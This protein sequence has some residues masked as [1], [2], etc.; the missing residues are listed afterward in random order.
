MLKIKNP[1]YL[2]LKT[3]NLLLKILKKKLRLQ[4]CKTSKKK[5]NFHKIEKIYIFGIS[6]FKKF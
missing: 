5:F 3:H 1:K 2:K 6:G 4:V